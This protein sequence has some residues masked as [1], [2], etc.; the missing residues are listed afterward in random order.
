MTVNMIED[1]LT[2]TGDR[3]IKFITITFLIKMIMFQITTNI[4]VS[5]IY[6]ELST[7]L[8]L[9]KWEQPNVTKQNVRSDEVV[10]NMLFLYK[11]IWADKIF[12]DS[13]VNKTIV[14]YMYC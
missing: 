3:P 9:F 12:D 4:I 11:L 14:L 13:Q 2:V 10:Q 1:G 8:L 7:I 5:T 6:K